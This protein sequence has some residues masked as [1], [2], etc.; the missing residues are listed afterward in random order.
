[1]IYTLV[2]IQGIQDMV[3]AFEE[4]CEEVIKILKTY[5]HIIFLCQ[6]LLIFIFYLGKECY[7]YKLWGYIRFSRTV[8]TYRICDILYR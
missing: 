4:N 5:I 7:F 2:P 3:R 6:I 1:M 8:T